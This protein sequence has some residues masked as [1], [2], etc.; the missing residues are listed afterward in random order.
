MIPGY[1]EWVPSIPLTGNGK[2][3]RKALPQPG[4]AAG[5][6]DATAQPRNDTEHALLALWREVLGVDSIGVHDNFFDL[7]GQS[8]KA[9]RLRA[10]IED[11]LNVTV[12]LRELFA[13]PTIAELALLV[14]GAGEPAPPTV[15]A[16]DAELAALMDELTPEEIEAQLRKLEN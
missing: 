9:V 5:G 11:V 3:D 16:V 8:L 12:S 7:G 15:A 10:R 6:T 14:G 2:V 4:A 1:V 13:Q